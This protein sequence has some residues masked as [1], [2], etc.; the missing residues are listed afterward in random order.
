[1]SGEN[2]PMYNKHG[3][4]NPNYG[5]THTEE[6]KKKISEAN[7]GKQSRN[8]GKPLSEETKKK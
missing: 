8:K 6:T 7:K 5:K 2:H 4:D 1:M 3:K